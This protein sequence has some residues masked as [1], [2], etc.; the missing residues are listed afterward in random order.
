MW[1]IRGHGYN[2]TNCSTLSKLS[3]DLYNRVEER[4]KFIFK[5][6]DHVDQ[7]TRVRKIIPFKTIGKTVQILFGLCDAICEGKSNNYVSKLNDENTTK[8]HLL[9]KQVKMIKYC[10][11]TKTGLK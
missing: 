2:Q 11:K 4:K 9:E 7:S 6:I 10:S 1:P 8:L 3:T 5:P